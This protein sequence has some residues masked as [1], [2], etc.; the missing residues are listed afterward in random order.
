[1]APTPDAGANRISCLENDEGKPSLGQVRGRGQS[2]R[3]GSE[4]GD[5]KLS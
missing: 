5:G 2:D 3:A 4:N 1:M